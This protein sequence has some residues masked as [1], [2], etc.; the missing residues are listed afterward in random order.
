MSEEEQGYPHCRVAIHM[1]GSVP[2]VFLHL[3]GDNTHVE[4]MALTYPT[5]PRYGGVEDM[6]E[7]MTVVPH[8]KNGMSNKLYEDIMDTVLAWL[9]A[10]S[11]LEIDRV[12][13]QAKSPYARDP[14]SK[15]KATRSEGQ[16]ST[17][18]RVGHT[19]EVKPWPS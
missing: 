17:M 14:I 7:Y 10:T 19:W 1:K 12:D 13:I 18:I 5:Y 2:V 11:R 4:N 9:T 15:M 8:L 6:T 16:W 3:H